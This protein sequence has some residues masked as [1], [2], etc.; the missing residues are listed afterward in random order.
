MKI[1]DHAIV[2]KCG[3]PQFSLLA[4]NYIGDYGCDMIRYGTEW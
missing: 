4:S 3:W 2:S 1:S